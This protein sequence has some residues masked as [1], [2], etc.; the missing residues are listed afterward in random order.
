MDCFS[1]DLGTVIRRSQGG[2]KQTLR[3]PATVPNGSSQHQCRCGRISNFAW[4]HEVKIRPALVQ[5]GSWVKRLQYLILSSASNSTDVC[6]QTASVE[7]SRSRCL[8]GLILD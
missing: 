2:T 6:T 4:S 3:R 7:G 5:W 8:F 1:P